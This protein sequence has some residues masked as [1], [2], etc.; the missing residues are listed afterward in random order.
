MAS[1]A[2][3]K[4]EFVMSLPAAMPPQ[5]VAAKAA[6]AGILMTAKVV[7]AVRSLTKARLARAQKAG[8]GEAPKRRG[9]P[10]GSRSRKPAHAPGSLEHALAELV[11]D[12]GVEALLGALAS[13]RERLQRSLV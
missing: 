10:L 4:T 11:L 7:N 5:E 9:R 8:A 2:P 12:H 13:L 3:N 6:E 1:Q